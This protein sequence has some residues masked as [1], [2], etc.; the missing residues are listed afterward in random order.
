MADKNNPYEA[1]AIIRDLPF[2]SYKLLKAANSSG[3]KTLLERSP[4]HV[5]GSE[6][7]SSPSLAMGTPVHSAVLE[8]KTLATDYVVAPNVSRNTNAGKAELV[9]WM[10]EVVGVEPPISNQKAEGRRLDEQIALLQPILDD[11]GLTLITAQQ[12]EQAQVIAKA[13]HA[14]PVAGP[15]LWDVEAEVTL[16]AND[17]RTGQLVKVRADALKTSNDLILDLKTAENASFNAF[18]R[19]AGRYQYHLQAA[20]YRWVYSWVIGRTP[21]FIHIVVETAPPYGVMVYDLDGEAILHG[22][23]RARTALNRWAECERSGHW[24]S[25]TPEIVSLSLPKWSL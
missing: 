2:E 18:A 23:A 13:V 10:C 11:K 17:P 8:P 4:A 1:P 21:G 14:H 20:L 16:L 7:K 15:L 5:H 12:H 3:L 9:A 22:E 6:P 24:P 19:A 25:Y